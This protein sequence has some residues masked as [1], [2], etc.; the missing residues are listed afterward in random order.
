MAIIITTLV[1]LFITFTVAVFFILGGML[2][3]F[4]G[5]WLN[6]RTAERSFVRDIQDTP[7][8]GE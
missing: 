8:P 2:G 6:R 1:V 4:V 3:A 7:S 5:S